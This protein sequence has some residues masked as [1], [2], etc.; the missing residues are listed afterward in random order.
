MI[1]FIIYAAGVVVEANLAAPT[2]IVA[3]DVSVAGT[4]LVAETK[5][6]VKVP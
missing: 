3:V 5:E 6:L 1:G 4:S 2:G